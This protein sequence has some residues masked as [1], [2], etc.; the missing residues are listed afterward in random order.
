MKSGDKEIMKEIEREYDKDEVFK[1]EINQTE[2]VEPI[3]KGL[4]EMGS[5]Y[6]KITGKLINEDNICYM[7]KKVLSDKEPIDIIKVP[8]NK[9]DKGLVAFVVV[10][11]ICN[12]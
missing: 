1:K 4:E 8:N 7:C 12:K 6:K 5:F 2:R 9:V 3:V 11:K 10:C